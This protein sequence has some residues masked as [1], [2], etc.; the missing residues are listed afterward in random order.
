MRF[1]TLAILILFS[2]YIHSQKLIT[3]PGYA[4][5]Q[6]HAIY[7]HY[8]LGELDD[9]SIAEYGLKLLKEA[10]VDEKTGL[11]LAHKVMSKTGIHLLFEITLNNTV[12]ADH[13]LK[14]NVD[15][16]GKVQSVFFNR[17]DTNAKF[18]SEQ[19][20]D[21]IKVI[22][23][24]STEGYVPESV[25]EMQNSW[26]ILDNQYLPVIELKVLPDAD[27]YLQLF[28]TNDKVVL[29]RS[30]T[31]HFETDTTLKVKVFLP[32]PLTTAGKTY[33]GNYVD[34]N[35]T[36]SPYLNNERFLKTVTGNYSTNFEL[37]NSFVTIDEHSS[38]VTTIPVLAT[39]S[40]YFKRS[41]S[42]FEDAN[43]FYHI[44][45]I[46][47]YLNSLGYTGLV[48]YQIRVDAHGLNGTDNSLFNPGANP[49]YLTFG[50]G[51]VDDAEDADVIVHEYTH[52]IIESASP[53]TNSGTE[54]QNLEEANCDYMA[55]SYSRSLNSFSWEKV[56]TWDGH[57]QYWSG[58]SAVTTKNYK[59][60]TFGGNIYEH[61]DL[62]CGTLMEIWGDLGRKTTDEILIE[63]LYSYSVGMSMPDA[64]HLFIQADSNL[65]GGAN[66]WKICPRFYNRGLWNNCTT[67]GINDDHGENQ[68]K[69]LN[70]YEFY[71]GNGT[72]KIM[73]PID[74][75]CQLFIFDT[76]GRV[77][78][79][80][81]LDADHIHINPTELPKGYYIGSIE[82]PSQRW[83]FVIQ[84]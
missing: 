70:S 72:L 48:N 1:I 7:P 66:Y 59:N 50:E 39:D 2:G 15:H 54:R 37:K 17:P 36:D 13:F 55:T 22:N 82:F 8:Q 9:A 76:V 65:N 62:W 47:E 26:L 81:H 83:N 80:K 5:K 20:P 24:V 58:R 71:R 84:R 57:N 25:T 53:S 11:K 27:H 4:I 42:G 77:V 63:S 51:G 73:V 35:D 28:V 41:E 75:P 49:P 43:A 69:I 67:L 33:G 19:F 60:I 52:A 30:L 16:N 46:K 64:A 44:T 38:P 6:A 3:P 68:I 31:R 78:L 34:N 29:S 14:V 10:N 45:T 18:L 21:S 79:K 32:D 74:G 61:T 12:I 56:Y 40:F 23:H